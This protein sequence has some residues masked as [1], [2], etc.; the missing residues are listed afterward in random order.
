M[1]RLENYTLAEIKN[2]NLED[3]LQAVDEIWDSIQTTDAS[4]TLSDE[5]KQM[6]DL[7]SREMEHQTDSGTEWGRLKQRVIKQLRR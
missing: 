2:L 7:A 6:L 1:G 5:E 3:R 4:I